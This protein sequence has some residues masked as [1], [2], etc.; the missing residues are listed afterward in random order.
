M[1]ALLMLNN[2]GI[3]R[4][5]GNDHTNSP[6]SVFIITMVNVICKLQMNI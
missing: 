5:K 6:V 4:I 1:S 2:D 3:N